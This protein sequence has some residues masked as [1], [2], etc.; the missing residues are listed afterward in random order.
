MGFSSI[1]TLMV[2]DEGSSFLIESFLSGSLTQTS[3]SSTVITLLTSN[4][5]GLKELVGTGSSS[6]TK[7]F[8]F[9]SLTW[10]STGLKVTTS[11]ASSVSVLIELMGTRSSF[12]TVSFLCGSLTWISE[13]LEVI[14]SPTSYVYRLIGLIEEG[15][16]EVTLKGPDRLAS[17]SLKGFLIILLW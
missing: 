9:G 17:G 13:G 2:L 4:I 11:F 7:F 14:I 3:A 8:L 6:S 16:V 10:I 5:S 15:W 12:S 1:L